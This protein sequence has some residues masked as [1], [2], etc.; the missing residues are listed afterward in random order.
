MEGAVIAQCNEPPMA[1]IG[2]D[3]CCCCG[4]SFSYPLPRY[5]ARRLILSLPSLSTLILHFIWVVETNSLLFFSSFILL[6]SILSHSYQFRRIN[7]NIVTQYGYLFRFHICPGVLSTLLLVKNYFLFSCSSEP[8]SPRV[9]LRWR[10]LNGHWLLEGKRRKQREGH[11][12]SFLSVVGPVLFSCSVLF[13]SGWEIAHV[14]IDTLLACWRHLLARAIDSFQDCQVQAVLCPSL[15]AASNVRQ[16]GTDD[17]DIPPIYTLA[18]GLYFFPNEKECDESPI[19][20]SV[21]SVNQ[22]K[23]RESFLREVKEC[24]SIDVW[25][26]D[27]GRWQIGSYRLN[28]WEMVLFPLYES[29]G[30]KKVNIILSATSRST[31]QSDHK[32]SSR[33]IRKELNPP[34]LWRILTDDKLTTTQSVV[35]TG[36]L[37]KKEKAKNVN[38]ILNEKSKFSFHF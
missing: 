11:W 1:R 21:I 5:L 13:V 4:F 19:F 7:K 6:L 15:V 30:T 26:D 2:H 3:S 12:S 32:M 37:K 9:Q 28:N 18:C 34:S 33:K 36:D 27:F 16:I 8:R 14:V 23:K 35:K 38:G 20:P 17:W 22:K 10:A 29:L 24:S 31:V 25:L